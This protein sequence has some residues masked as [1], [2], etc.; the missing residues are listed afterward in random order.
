VMATHS[1][2]AAERCDDRVTLSDGRIQ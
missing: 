2:E 1:G